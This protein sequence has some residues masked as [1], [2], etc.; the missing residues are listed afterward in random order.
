[1]KK[2]A[3]LLVVVGIFMLAASMALGQS[4]WA[5][6]KENPLKQC[7]VCVDNVECYVAEGYKGPRIY[8]FDYE[9]PSGNCTVEYYTLDCC[10]CHG[11]NAPGNHG[12]P[13]F[14]DIQCP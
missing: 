6:Y 3:V 12:G 7:T 11:P 4:E 5:Y 10:A 2:V 1:M 9:E 8:I 13:Q 14:P